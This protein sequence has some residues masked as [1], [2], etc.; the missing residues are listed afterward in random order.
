MSQTDR[1]AFLRAIWESPDDDSPRLV[2][3]DW[4]DEHGEPDRAEL[5]RAQCHLERLPGTSPDLADAARRAAEALARF[6]SSPRFV[7]PGPWATDYLYRR[8]FVEVIHCDAVDW[9]QRGEAFRLGEPV[10][11]LSL[12]VVG[13][14]AVPALSPSLAGLDSLTLTLQRPLS[15]REALALVESPHL[16]GL[17]ELILR[18]SGGEQW[19]GEPA[20]RSLAR[21][22]GLWRLRRLD[23]CGQLVTSESAARL[24]RRFGPGLVGVVEV[25]PEEQIPF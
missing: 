12:R 5:I 2:F 22:R 14:A 19:F 17:R 7:E 20:A 24:R 18:R 3:A 4:L 11:E 9:F 23:L 15:G 6:R 10:R 16:A 8:G 21:P 13:G 1:D 25:D